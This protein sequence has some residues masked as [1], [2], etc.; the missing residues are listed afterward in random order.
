M[1]WSDGRPITANDWVVTARINLDEKNETVNL[2]SYIVNDKPIQVVAVNPDTLRVTFPAVIA[3]AFYRMT[4]LDVQPAHIF[5]PAAE[6]GPCRPQGALAG[7]RGRGRRRLG[8][9]LQVPEL[10]A[11]ERV[12]LVK[13]PFYGEWNKDSAGKALPYADGFQVS[14]Y[15]DANAQFAG[16]LAGETDMFTP[17]GAD[18]LAQLTRAVQG[19]QLRATIRA[20]VSSAATGDRIAFNWNKSSDPWKQALFRNV[21][22]RRAMSHLTNRAAM[23]QLAVGGLGQPYYSMVYPVLNQFQSPRL[24][25]YDFNPEAAT[26]LL[27]KVGFTRKNA[28]GTLVDRTGRALEFD[29]SPN[30]GNARR[31]AIAQVFSDEAKKVGREGERAP[32][33]HRHLELPPQR[34]RHEPQLRRPDL[35]HRRRR[36]DS[37]LLERDHRL[38][39]QPD[40]LEQA[41]T[42]IQPWGD[43]DAGP[44]QPGRARARR[45]Q[46][47]GARLPDQEL[48]AGTSPTSTPSPRTITYAWNNR[49]R[50]ELPQNLMNALNGQ[51]YYELTW[52]QQ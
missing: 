8:R 52:V 21:D 33:G 34:H 36:P 42:C 45:R 18:D 16:F 44:L 12:N 13:N 9:R 28:E 25:K 46:A 24:P 4:I 51:R 31:A 2:D 35:R 37:A 7:E 5:G 47:Q 19:N 49:L 39:G 40:G 22:F 26:A 6:R 1:K 43:P 50:G 23:V 30:A 11:G 15:R 29:I 17:R 27:R 14:I 32:R 20:N 3:Q 10:R 41:E 48:E 38:Q